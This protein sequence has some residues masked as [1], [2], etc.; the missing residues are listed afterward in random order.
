MLAQVIPFPSD[1]VVV[2]HGHPVTTSIKVAE[3][4]NKRHRDV[5]RTIKDLDCPEDFS[6]RNFARTSYTDIQGK[7]WPMFELTRDGLTFLVMGFTGHEAALRKIEYIKRFNEMEEALRNG[8]PLVDALQLADLIRQAVAAAMPQAVS[9]EPRKQVM[10]DA[11]DYELLKLKVEQGIFRKPFTDDE[12][13]TMRVLKAQDWKDRAIGEK[14]GR[15]QDSVSD[16]FRRERLK[17]KPV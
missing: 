1:A 12:K 3:V 10:V 2:K 6:E 4:F 17:N 5:L 14:I 13:T 16:F 9:T 7:S 15:S 11:A 8:P